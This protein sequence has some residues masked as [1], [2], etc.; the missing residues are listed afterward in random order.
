[1]TT[2]DSSTER[3]VP[4]AGDLLHPNASQAWRQE[5][6]KAKAPAISGY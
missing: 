2:L 5:Q 3:A 6:K 4:V 1:M